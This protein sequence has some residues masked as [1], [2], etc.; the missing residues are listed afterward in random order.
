MTTTEIKSLQRDDHPARV[1]LERVMACHARGSAGWH[2]TDCREF[3]SVL[4]DVRNWLD[5]RP[6]R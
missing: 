1:L 6:S 4:Q 3:A 5:E 2:G